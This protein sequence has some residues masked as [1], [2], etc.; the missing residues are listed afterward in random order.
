MSATNRGGRP[1]MKDD[2]YLT[3]AWLVR[4]LLEA[5]PL[6]PGDWLEPAAGMGSIIS[7]AH[8]LR[9]PA[10]W[11]AVEVR[12]EC[13]PYLAQI[14]PDLVIGDFVKTVAPRFRDEHRH[15]KVGITNPP[16]CLADKYISAL[17]PMC[18]WVVL[19]L[20]MNY[21]CTE[22]HATSFGEF[23]PDLYCSRD[24]PSFTPN[25]R[26]DST[27]YAWHVWG[28]PATR[29]RDAGKWSLLE[30]TPAA[31]RRYRAPVTLQPDMFT[32]PPEL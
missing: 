3:P 5:L 13:R 12:E 28:P 7:T 21:L 8:D 22:T 23:L 24:R 32:P 20:R 11:T 2:V 4:R 17:L 14:V 25:G 27:A 10:K 30:G 1:R 31:T 18:E 26:A 16:F 29:V 19:L 9:V 6:P 15:F